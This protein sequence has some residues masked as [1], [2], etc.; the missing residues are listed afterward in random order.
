MNIERTGQ[1]FE[2]EEKVRRLFGNNMWHTIMEPT[3]PYNATNPCMHEKC[4]EIAAGG[5]AII[6]CWG[7]VYQVDVCPLH[8]KQYHGLCFDLFPYKKD[9]KLVEQSEQGVSS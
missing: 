3:F 5:R 9:W 2:L 1:D 4:G 7:T 6:N 8:Y